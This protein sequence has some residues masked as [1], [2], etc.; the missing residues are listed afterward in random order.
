MFWKTNDLAGD[1][2]A[3]DRHRATNTSFLEASKMQ[4]TNPSRLSAGASRHENSVNISA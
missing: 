3:S 2:K 1:L 4:I